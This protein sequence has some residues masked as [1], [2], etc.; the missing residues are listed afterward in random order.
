MDV[1]LLNFGPEAGHQKTRAYFIG[2][3]GE[4]GGGGGFFKS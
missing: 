4:G 3:K 1:Y 2:G